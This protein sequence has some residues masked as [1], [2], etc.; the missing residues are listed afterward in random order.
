MAAGGG[1]LG[2]G[3]S[4]QNASNIFFGASSTWQ[5]CKK[6]FI[7][8][9]GE[10]EEAFLHAPGA[11]ALLSALNTTNPHSA[12]D[13]SWT[14]D[15]TWP[16][17]VTW[18]IQSSDD[19]SSGPWDDVETNWD[20]AGGD[21]EYTVG[22]LNPNTTYWFRVAAINYQG[23]SAWSNI[24][25][26]I[27]EWAPITQTPTWASGYPKDD[28][29][30]ANSVLVKANAITDDYNLYRFYWK[31]NASLDGTG[32]NPPTNADGNFTRSDPTAEYDHSE[33]GWGDGDVIHYRMRAENPHQV[34]PCTTSD[35]T[36]TIE[37][38]LS[39]PNAP[40]G[41]SATN[42]GGE[43]YMAITWNDNSSDE[44]NFRIERR[45][46]VCGGSYGSYSFLTDRNENV[47]SYDWY[48]ATEGYEYQ[49]RVRAEN[50]AG[51]SSWAYSNEE[52]Y[53]SAP[54]TPTG[55]AAVKDATNPDVSADVSWNNALTGMHDDTEVYRSFTSP[56]TPPGQGTLVATRSASYESYDD[57]NIVSAL[58]TPSAPTVTAIGDDELRISGYTV[59]DGDE[60]DIHRGSSSG[61][62]PSESNRVTTTS[63]TTYDDDDGGNGL[64]PD[65]TY[66]YKVLARANGLNVYYRVIATND[67]GDS[68]SASNTGSTTLDDRESGYSSAG[69][70]ATWPNAPKNFSAQN[71]MEAD[72]C[73]PPQ[74]DLT[75]SNGGREET[76]S[77][78]VYNW[79]TTSWDTISGSIGATATSYLNH[80][81]SS[82][83]IHS[84]TKDVDY[85]IR[86]NTSSTW[87][88]DTANGTC[89]E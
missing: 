79:I 24:T 84:T 13:L 10:W 1:F 69:S 4:W 6:V 23:Q 55:C 62:T 86:F 63:A 78:E 28:P 45:S 41:V 68:S 21:L 81:P 65:T 33:T 27:T 82:N 17:G 87:A 29:I 8:V 51:E 48:G 31:K 39:P 36:A 22:S 75:W 71:D 66:Y 64:D 11:P 35:A 40:S 20:P 9:S 26:K 74:I 73:P 38:P 60:Y 59:G 58:S 70:G 56:F 49:F 12:V 61:F 88:T 30:D 72:P 7:G 57:N 15:T 53:W 2:S 52:E 18:Y 44:D 50:A 16:T 83:Q 5:D 14:Q 47:E 32:G 76:K 34:G 80:Q 19:S 77:L 43:S 54:G 46:R 37:T 3:S 67:C 42:T 85:R 89:P 25:S